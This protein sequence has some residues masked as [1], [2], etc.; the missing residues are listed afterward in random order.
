MGARKQLPF[1]ANAECVSSLLIYEMFALPITS[2]VGV[3]HHPGSLDFARR[4]FP[5][6]LAD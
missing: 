2:I 3:V 1:D 4:S 5:A 6:T